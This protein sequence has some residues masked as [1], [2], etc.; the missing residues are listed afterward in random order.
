MLE[1]SVT[2]LYSLYF[3]WDK[4]HKLTFSDNNLIVDGL[5]FREIFPGWFGCVEFALKF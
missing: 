2:G 4:F 5:L 1:S 3:N